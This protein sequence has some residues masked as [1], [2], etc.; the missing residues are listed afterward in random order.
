MRRI[1]VLSIVTLLTACTGFSSNSDSIGSYPR[2][3]SIAIAS[4]IKYVPYDHGYMEIPSIKAIIDQCERNNFAHCRD[5]NIPANS[6]TEFDRNKDKKVYVFVQLGGLEQ[7]RNLETTIRLFDP[8]SNLVAQL[9]F[10]THVP[11]DF[12]SKNNLTFSF[13]WGPPDPATWSLGT[14]R[15]EILINKEVIKRTFQVVDKK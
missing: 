8:D 12:Q 4:E 10:P 5:Y 11:R 13:N 14:W 7:D 6:I 9:D 1:I 15:I 3:I 2:R